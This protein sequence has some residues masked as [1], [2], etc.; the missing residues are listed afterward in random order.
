M[1]KFDND[2]VTQLAEVFKALSN[3]HR[4]RLFLRLVPSCANGHCCTSRESERCCVG[5]LGQDTGLAPSTVSHH[6]KELRRAGLLRIERCGQKTECSI[7]PEAVEALKE[8][9]G[10]SC[11][12]C[13]TQ[14]AQP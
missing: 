3:P 14:G 5:D 4:L 8:F 2:L 11:E 9:F 6:L 1:S 12:A 13:G 10:G 7:N